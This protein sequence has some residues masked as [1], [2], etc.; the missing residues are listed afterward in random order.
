MKKVD[1]EGVRNPI[2]YISIAIILGSVFWG[3]YKSEYIWLAALA[4]SLFFITVLLKSNFIFLIIIFLFFALSVFNNFNYYNLKIKEEFNGE[5]KILEVKSYCITGKFKERLI[6]IEGGKNKFK[7]GDKVRVEGKFEKGLDFEKG[8][9]GT[10]KINKINDVSDSLRR[11]L[12]RLREE[13]YEN[14]NDNIGERKSA[15]LCSMAFGY[16]DNIDEADREEMQN[17][18]VIHVISVS[19]LHVALIYSILKKLFGIR[20]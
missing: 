12:Y 20:L 5:I 3:F 11:K 15:L 13:V 7:I 1:I 14:L 10:I 19:G 17:F 6:N 16:S 4:V 18:G 9:I 2:V 8:I